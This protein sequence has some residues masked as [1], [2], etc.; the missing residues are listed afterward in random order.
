MSKIV[1]YDQEAS[2][3]VRLEVQAVQT[4]HTVSIRLL[5][6]S[7]ATNRRRTS[8]SQLFARRFE[9]GFPK[10]IVQPRVMHFCH[11]IRCQST[12]TSLVTTP[13]VETRSFSPYPF[14]A[15]SEAFKAPRL[16]NR[17]RQSCLPYF[18]QLHYY[19]LIDQLIFIENTHAGAR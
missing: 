7:G 16:A 4:P 3:R 18:A 17:V 6:D 9:K 1:V 13:I 5:R 14:P 15:C 2:G 10:D 8:S 12:S 19:S 11:D